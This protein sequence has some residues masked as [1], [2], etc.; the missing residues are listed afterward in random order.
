MI[1]LQNLYSLWHRCEAIKVNCVPELMAYPTVFL[2]PK[3]EFLELDNVFGCFRKPKQYPNQI[4]CPIEKIFIF[5]ELR[6]DFRRSQKKFMQLF[7]ISWFRPKFSRFQRRFPLKVI[8]W[9]PSRLF[10]QVFDWIHF[11]PDR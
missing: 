3:F 4:F 9:K 11:T 2:V 10:L 8:F 5:R 1:F 6:A 7:V